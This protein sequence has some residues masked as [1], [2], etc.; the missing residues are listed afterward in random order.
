[1]SLDELHA[2]RLATIGNLFDAA[3]DR[4]SLTLQ[5]A[6]EVRD[7]GDASVFP[8]SKRVLYGQNRGDSNLSTRVCRC[9]TCGCKSPIRSRCW[10][11]AFHALVVLENAARAHDA[12]GGNF[13]ADQANWE[14]LVQTSCKTE[15]IRARF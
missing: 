9:S 14:N 4:M 15:L 10:C 8:L 13:P 7:G 6:D 5:S 11:G 1:M 3:L 12:T 2:R